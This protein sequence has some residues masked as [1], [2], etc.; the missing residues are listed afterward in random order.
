[1]VNVKNIFRNINIIVRLR[2]NVNIYRDIKKYSGILK[3]KYKNK[4]YSIG[5]LFNY[6]LFYQAFFSL[7][8]SF[9]RVDIFSF[10][11]QTVV[12]SQII[13]NVYSY[14]NEKYFLI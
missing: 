10:I 2:M 4:G 7:N 3:R 9:S 13:T 6:F 11:L 14:S 1:M 12:F 5:I 8:T